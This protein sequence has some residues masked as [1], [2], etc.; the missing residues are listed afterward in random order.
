MIPLPLSELE[1]QLRDLLKDPDT[2]PHFAELL[3][4]GVSGYPEVKLGLLCLL[5]N[6][7][8]SP[9]QR[10][11]IHVLLHGKPGT[12]KTALMAPLEQNFSAKYLSMDP[13]SSS[14]KSDGRKKDRGA[15]IF[16]K[17]N[18]GIVC[19]DDFELMTD[20]NSLRDVMEKG[21]YTDA[22]GGTDTLYNAYVRIVAATN[23]I[24]KVP[25]PIVSRFDLVFKFNAPTL[26]QS[27]NI[28]RQMLSDDESDIDYLPMLRHYLYLAHTWKPKTVH[29]RKIEQCFEAYFRENGLPTEEG[30][31]GKEGRW[32]ATI[33]RLSNA[34]ASI[35]L[36][37]IGPAQIEQAL[38]IKHRSDEIVRKE[39][40]Q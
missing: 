24:R 5:V 40:K 36:T 27:M 3:F 6:E 15:Q 20:Q 29:K 8:D 9:G 21:Q 11:R 16:N 33:I 26:N 12:G 10:E 22:S 37:D 19:I 14:L 17:C 39:L 31:G 7:W 23:D 1:S 4:P 25:T 32:I 18:G 35:G 38:K 2:V 34:L 28:V 13:R 30:P